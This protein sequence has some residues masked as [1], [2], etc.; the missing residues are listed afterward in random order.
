M[1]TRRWKAS[2]ELL[3][4][5]QAVGRASLLYDIQDSHSGNMAVRWKDEAGKEQI[6]ITATGS[7]KGDLEPSQV[8]FL[9]V[10][11]TDYG[12]YKASSET[13]IHARILALD[14]VN[15]SMHAHTKDLTI[16][17]LDDEQ[18]PS[19]PA[20][21][22]PIDQL[23]YYY[24]GSSIP[25]DW[26]EV[27]SG[28]AEMTKKIPERLAR[29]PATV[30]Q[31][32]GVFTKGR[33]LKEA[34]FLACVANNS[35]SIIRLAAKSGADIEGIR[36]TIQSEP[37]FLFPYPL[38][39]YA[40][41]GDERCDFP[42]EEEMVKEFYKSGARIF[43]SRLSPFH[44]GSMSVRGVQKMLYAPKASMPRELKGPLLSVPLSPE[45]SDSDE[46]GFHKEIYAHSNFQTVLHCHL[47]E[48]EALSHAVS[49]GSN[50]R[51]DR[52]VPVDAEGSFL[53]L[54]IPVLAPKFEFKE[55]IR[56]LHDY[57]VVIVRGGGVWGVG[58]QSL[59][60]VL[61]HPSSVREICLYRI[62]ALERGLDLQN[63]EPIKAKRW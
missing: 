4:L 1:T 22:V 8:C 21:F 42:E 43:E 62:G 41:E 58:T 13:D 52:I 26:F 47:P 37:D 36:R 7:Q 59:S 19:Q 49:P 28:S 50:E 53:Y 17:T 18:K 15:A 2:Q 10:S 56:L 35:G 5:F 9:S 6:V 14:G 25:V 57:K 20:P 63:M 45:K 12:Y 48:A 61:H 3:R 11:E 44:T 29:H 32:H 30:I 23:G 33:N 24:L 51:C 27:P 16:A 31:G 38:A 54:V 60:E 46:M 39:D 55:F 40:V 34:F